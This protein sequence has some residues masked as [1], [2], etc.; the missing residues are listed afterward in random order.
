MFTHGLAVHTP[1]VGICDGGECNLFRPCLVGFDTV[2]AEGVLDIDMEDVQDFL[3]GVQ[4]FTSFDASGPDPSGEVREKRGGF[5]D[6]R[7]FSD[8][9]ADFSN[10][11]TDTEFGGNG[12]SK[13]GRFGGY[14]RVGD[15]I[16]GDDIPQQK[17]HISPKS[18][19]GEGCNFTFEF[20]G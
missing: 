14:P 7:I 1:V 2:S 10:L 20:F 19:A 11:A 8:L 17:P 5:G 9:L 6:G 16:G 12:C 15:T 13:R 3:L 4:E 18:V